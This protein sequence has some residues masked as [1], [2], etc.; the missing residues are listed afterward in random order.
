MMQIEAICLLVLSL[1]LQGLTLEDIL[2]QFRETLLGT[3]TVQFPITI[4]ARSMISVRN[5]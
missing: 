1:L 4:D 5:R 2:D 3:L